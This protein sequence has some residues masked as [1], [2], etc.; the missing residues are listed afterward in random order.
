MKTLTI[1]AKLTLG[2]GFV[3][4][5]FVALAC[6]SGNRMAKINDILISVTKGSNVIT[7]EL[8]EMQQSVMAMSAS[9]TT[10]VLVMD[11]QQML[12]EASRVER[13]ALRYKSKRGS[14]TAEAGWHPCG[15]RPDRCTVVS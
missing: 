2:F 6:I 1:G 8:N 11:E 15:K 7:R 3:L 14:H 9:I 13:A 4:L 12:A 5:L 10:I